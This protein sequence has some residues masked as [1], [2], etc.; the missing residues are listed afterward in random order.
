M[1]LFASS[2]LI[3]ASIVFSSIE[4]SSD[5]TLESRSSICVTEVSSAGLTR[6]VF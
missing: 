1:T 5:W 2:I 4:S 3:V 6:L